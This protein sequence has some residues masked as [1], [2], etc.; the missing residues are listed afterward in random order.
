[1]EQQELVR[2]GYFA[3]GPWAHRALEKITSDDSK[4][5]EF[6]C[7]RYDR[8]DQ[9]LKEM[10]K[11]RNI[12]FLTHPKINS[13]DFLSQVQA[14]GCDL[15]VSM[16]FNQIFRKE[17]IEMPAFKTINCHAGKLPFYRGRNILNWVLIN[18]E[19]EFG[20]T[21]HFMDEGIDTGDIL[22][23][24]C[25]PISDLDNYRTL[26]EQ[27][28]VLCA[29]VVYKAI[30]Q[31]QKGLAKPRH[32]SEIHPVGMYCCARQEGDEILNWEQTSREI[33]NFVRAICS[34]GPQARS[35]LN[36]IEMRI[37]RVELIH[38]SPKYLGIPGVVVGKG[39]GYFIVKS[40]DSTVRVT[41]WNFTNEVRIGD[42]F[43]QH[44]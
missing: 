35:F 38:E 26:L 15:F 43:K 27:A 44:R 2:I 7:A 3:D 9:I 39:L 29:E 40:L 31:L 36:G 41:D 22:V 1:L 20:V 10:A 34:P 13:K 6:I 33:F 5:I 16:S 24:E 21:A 12:P 37:E 8:P 42:R 23:Q 17:L 18:D 32:Q 11:S 4:R 14:Y 25:L 30:D 28:Y 19:K